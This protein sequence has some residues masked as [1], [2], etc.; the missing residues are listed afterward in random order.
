MEA[1]IEEPILSRLDRL[2]N[3]IKKLEEVRGG[4]HS[5]KSSTASSETL[6]TSDGQVSSLDFSPRSMEKHCRPI[7]DVISETEHK[8]TLIERLV[9]VEN[10]VLNVCA[11]LEAELE[12]M[13]KK[14]QEDL[15][16]EENLKKKREEN[17]VVIEEEDRAPHKKGT[18]KSF[19]KS[20]VKGTGIGKHNRKI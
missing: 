8:G 11:Q 13:K 15:A 17:D 16:V 7:D 3:I 1:V 9:N 20:C 2:D 5:S 4:D 14:K 6:T 19:V 18:F 10:R 12:L